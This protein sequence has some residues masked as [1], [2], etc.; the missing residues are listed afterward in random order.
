MVKGQGG[1][2]VPAR[3]D[4]LYVDVPTFVRR[5]GEACTALDLLFDQITNVQDWQVNPSHERRGEAGLPEPG[6]TKAARRVDGLM[7]TGWA[8]PYETGGERTR[9]VPHRRTTG[10]GRRAVDLAGSGS[11]RG[12][13]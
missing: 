7:R 5:A 8:D 6:G 13:R 1:K 11:G 3:P 4:P 9:Q 10:P 12:L 2:T